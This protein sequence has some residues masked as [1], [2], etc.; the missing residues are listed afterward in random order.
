MS[1]QVEK[2][3]VLN[4]IPKSGTNYFRIFLANYLSLLSDPE[5]KQNV[6]YAQTSELFPNLTDDYI[7]GIQVP[8]NPLV[9]SVTA[10]KDF[11]YSHR[12]VSPKRCKPYR[13]FAIYLYR[14]PLDV[15]VS[16]YYYKVAHRPFQK[17]SIR[18]PPD[19]A[20]EYIQQY[21]NRY[22]TM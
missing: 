18:N 10:Y 3:L 20:K 12:V 6:T 13:S 15:M 14:N 4:S 2:L 1:E 17:S 11:V 19:M 21:I 8:P 22:V 7:K 5:M 9:N 16:R